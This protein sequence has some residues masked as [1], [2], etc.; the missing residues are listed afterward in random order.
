MGHEVTA[1]A[2]APQ[3]ITLQHERLRVVKGDVLHADAVMSAMKDQQQA[4]IC[5][6]G[7]AVGTAPGIIISEGSRNITQAMK[8]E[9]VR[10]LVFESSIMV[11]DGLGL[12][13]LNRFLLGIFRNLN[14]PCN[15]AMEPFKTGAQGLITFPQTLT[16]M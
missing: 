5:S 9:R 7:P 2:R 15:A 11:G 8:P 3:Q 13:A 10:R 12:S 16:A 14:V 4:V 1:L 6:L